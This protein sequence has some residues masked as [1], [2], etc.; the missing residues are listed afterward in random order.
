MGWLLLRGQ[1]SLREHTPI[2]V[3]R[4]AQ[5]V[6]LL[7]VSR[8]SSLFDSVVGDD[9]KIIAPACFSGQRHQKK[10]PTNRETLH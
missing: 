5:K 2:V 6:S 9:A 10:C 8:V 4:G 1:V 7:F 3:Y